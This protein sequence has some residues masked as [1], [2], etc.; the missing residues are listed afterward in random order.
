MN[1]NFN[2]EIKYP[3]HAINISYYKDLEKKTIIAKKTYFTILNTYYSEA[4]NFV[5]IN[6]L[7]Y[8]MVKTYP[9]QN[10]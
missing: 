1:L 7:I 6:S 3:Y 2:Q 10:A 8:F 9:M 5:K 4:H